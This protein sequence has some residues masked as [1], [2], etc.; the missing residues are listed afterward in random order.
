MEAATDQVTGNG[1]VSPTRPLSGGTRHA[2]SY[3]SCNQHHLQR[4][5]SG[6]DP[7]QQSCTRPG[8]HLKQQQPGHSKQMFIAMG[9]QPQLLRFSN[10]CNVPCQSFLII[11][12]H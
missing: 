9:Q 7:H 5:S 2:P 10:G 1:L 6:C 11:G 4:L 12:A 3:S 8:L